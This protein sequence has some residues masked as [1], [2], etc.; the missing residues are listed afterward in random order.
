MQSSFAHSEFQL[1]VRRLPQSRTFS[2][3]ADLLTP[4]DYNPVVPC[5][6][7]PVPCVL[8]HLEI[9]SNGSELSPI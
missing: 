2:P 7:C 4:H 6:I 5:S 8:V 1:L 9:L 3:L